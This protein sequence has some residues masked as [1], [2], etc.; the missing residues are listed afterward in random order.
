MRW[1]SLLG[2]PE[3][4]RALGPAATALR[5]TLLS[6]LI[7][8]VGSWAVRT[9]TLV[10]AALGLL[11]RRVLLAPATWLLLAMLTGLRLVLD[12]PL[13]DNHAYLLAYWCLAVFLALVSSTPEGVLAGAARWLVGLAFLFSVLWK[14]L[15]APEYLDGRFF[16]VTLMTDNRFAEAAM[17]FGGLTEEDLRRTR[18]ALR[19]LP[20]G[21]ALLDPPVLVEPPAFRGLAAAAT[22]WLVGIESLV[23]V[24][25][26]GWRRGWF[27]HFALI[28]FCVLTYA[29]APV[30]GFGWLL[31]ALGLAQCDPNERGLRAAYVTSFFLVLAYA[32]VP[33]TRL[34]LSLRGG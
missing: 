12:W 10:L 9:P 33:W 28:G 7:L 13:P 26:L 6:V 23:A 11:E 21:A 17:L 1:R 3:A 20:A 24:A 32:G 14:V 8:P 16:R 5:L 19:P 27:R 25:F 2:H 18:E 30:A 22:W 4:E 34:L 15:L 29:M 31:L